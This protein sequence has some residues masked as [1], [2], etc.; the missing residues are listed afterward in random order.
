MR[1]K[2]STANPEDLADI[3]IILQQLEELYSKLE[4]LYKEQQQLVIRAPAS[5]V[6]VD[7]EDSLHKNR[8]IN[9]TLPLAFIID[10]HT[11]IIR[12]VLPETEL[13]RVHVAKEAVFIPDDLARGKIIA[14]VKDIELANTR[15]LDI[16]YISSV[17]G[18]DIAVQMDNDKNLVPENSVYQVRLI[19]DEQLKNIPTNVIRGIV[20]IEGEARSFARRIYDIGASVIIRESGF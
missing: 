7:L 12:G 13:A 18:G 6:I 11:A 2:R 5:G 3:Q 8:W 1:A 15:Y 16:P 17:Y 19:M 9:E 10:P 4:G 20:H 14:H